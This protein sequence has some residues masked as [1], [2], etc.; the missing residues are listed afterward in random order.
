MWLETYNLPSPTEEEKLYLNILTLA[1]LNEKDDNEKQKLKSIHFYYMYELI[2]K[3]LTPIWE[4]ESII[5]FDKFADVNDFLN[6]DMNN[7]NYSD[8]KI[9]EDN[10]GNYRKWITNNYKSVNDFT[11]PFEDK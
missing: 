4:K 7:I 10:K 6:T 2:D 5:D 1:Y 9:D 11:K 3:Y 8:F